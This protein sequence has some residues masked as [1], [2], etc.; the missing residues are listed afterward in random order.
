MAVEKLNLIFLA[1]CPAD[2][3]MPN[4]KVAINNNKAFFISSAIGLWGKN[5]IIILN[6]AEFFYKKTKKP[7]EHPK[8]KKAEGS[9]LHPHV[10]HSATFDGEITLNCDFYCVA[11]SLTSAKALE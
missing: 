11:S 3:P 2:D 8:N 6:Q 9:P 7:F 5:I 4:N 10:L 1:V